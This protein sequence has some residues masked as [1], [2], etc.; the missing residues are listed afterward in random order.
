[1]LEAGNEKNR[2]GRFSF[3]RYCSG[4][5]DRIWVVTQERMNDEERHH[6]LLSTFHFSKIGFAVL[7]YNDLACIVDLAVFQNNL[8]NYIVAEVYMTI[9]KREGTM[10]KT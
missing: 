7:L 5:R 6:G 9:I 1:M 8:R 4:A 2:A 10:S 3:R